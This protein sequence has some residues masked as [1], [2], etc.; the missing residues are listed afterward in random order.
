MTKFFALVDCN[1]FY[2]SCERVFRPDLEGRPVAVLSNND[3]CVV[4]RSSEVKALGV[5]MGVPF[6]E[7][8]ALFQRHGVAVF[9]SNYELYGDLSARVM[10]VLARYSPDLE[11]Y[12]IDEAFLGL[13]GFE[14]WDLNA[15]LGELRRTVRR[16]TGIPVSVGAAP[17]KTLAKVAAGR[18]K[19]TPELGGVL[20]LDTPAAVA[21]ALALT[22][23]GDV[24]GIGRRWSKRLEA[25]G[26]QT[27]LEFSR[28][29]EA[30]VRKTMGVTGARTLLELRGQPCLGLETQPADR[31]SC[32]ASRSF[33]QTVTAFDDVKDAVATFAA[34]AGERLRHGHGSGGAMVAGQVCAFALTDR[35]AENA[36]Q[37][38]AA[39]TVALETPSN[40]TVDLTRAALAA[41]RRAYRPGYRYKK[42]GVMLLD[43]APETRA[44]PTLFAPTVEDRDKAERLQRALDGL[45]GSARGGGRDLVRLG[46]AGF[47]HGGHLR[48]EHRS[49]RYTT[50]WSELK[51]V[52]A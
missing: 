10:A 30:R 44:Q 41:L 31:K 18:A 47:G 33:A 13:D 29:P 16:W 43:L 35:F 7:V 50:H 14:R 28:Q 4:A 38:H 48:R 32:V 1:N 39:A 27:A 11:V 6:F 15:H 12:S 40:L 20:V 46:A 34:R 36:P 45:N 49:P 19:K 17:T 2:A 42:A 5:A 25:M 22:P 8:R 21:A 37:C 9:S 3:G 24:W 26:I 23:V 52:R 51:R